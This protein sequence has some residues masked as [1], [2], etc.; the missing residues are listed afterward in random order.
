MNILVLPEKASGQ[1][2]TPGKRGLSS[3]HIQ[4]RIL[5]ARRI[6]FLLADVTRI[7]GVEY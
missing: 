1:V 4:C 2:P 3:F 7:I 6:E 5:D